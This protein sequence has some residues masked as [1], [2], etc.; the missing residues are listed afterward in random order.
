MK[1]TEIPENGELSQGMIGDELQ[2]SVVE[3]TV[4]LYQKHGFVRPWV[5]YLA[6]NDSGAVGT[7]GFKSPPSSG[8]V[9]IAYFTFPGHEGR[10]V[11]TA[12][13]KELVHIANHAYPGIQIVAQTLREESASTTILRKLG[14]ELSG[15]IEHP[16]DGMV[17]EWTL[18]S[19]H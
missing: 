10:G 14:F 7:C 19:S 1:L 9:E 8:R 2:R 6:A 16:D 12:M 11:A 15:T 17:W 5:G 3:S 13:A 18:T 4:A